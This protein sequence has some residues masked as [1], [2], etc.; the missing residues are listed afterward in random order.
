MVMRWGGCRS[1]AVGMGFEGS[2]SRGVVKRR[3]EQ[4]MGY[5][6]AGVQP[7]NGRSARQ[8]IDKRSQ[9]ENGERER[10]RDGAMEQRKIRARHTD[11]ITAVFS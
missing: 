6:R 3:A 5:K 11:E 10:E 1:A 4:R 9:R 2:V 7:E 8:V